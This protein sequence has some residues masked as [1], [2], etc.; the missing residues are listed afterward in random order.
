MCFFVLNRFLGFV[1]GLFAAFVS[2]K[3]L[4]QRFVSF[5]LLFLRFVQVFFVFNIICYFLKR[6]LGFAQ[7]CFFFC[8]TRQ[9][10]LGL[11]LLRFA[12][13]F[14][15]RVFNVSS[16]LSFVVV[17]FWGVGELFWGHFN[18]DCFDCFL[19]FLFFV[20]TFSVGLCCFFFILFLFQGFFCCLLADLGG[21][22]SGFFQPG[23][24]SCCELFFL[25]LLFG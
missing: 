8:L 24:F 10:V 23:L 1:L 5:K 11:F 17:F 14:R 13:V 21:S 16:Q 7:G 22:L 18:F 9:A 20:F 12:L 19:V 25:A 2:F 6:C 4:L 3:L 15:F